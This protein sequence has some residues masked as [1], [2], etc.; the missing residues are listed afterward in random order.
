MQNFSK[1]ALPGFTLVE[2]GIVL[3][4]LI[5]LAS[6]SCAYWNV[7]SSYRA[8]SALDILYLECM[9]AQRCA[10]VHNKPVYLQFNADRHSYSCQGREHTL[11]PFLAFGVLGQV[12]G[13]PSSPTTVVTSP[14]TFTNHCITFWPSGI[15]Q[16][17]TIYI[18]D[19]HTSQHYALSCAVSSVSHIR[20]YHYDGRWKILR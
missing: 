19:T 15:I 11:A 16:A 10:Q 7:L 4:L 12:Y 18:V 3:V 20:K 14:I 1:R 6:L 5:L 13:P 9:H 2:V 17:G 8:R